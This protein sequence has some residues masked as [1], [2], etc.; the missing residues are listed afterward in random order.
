MS[1]GESVTI[2]EILNFKAACL[3]AM[4]EQRKRDWLNKVNSR[5]RNKRK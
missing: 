3:K 2:N 4:D 1:R 5:P